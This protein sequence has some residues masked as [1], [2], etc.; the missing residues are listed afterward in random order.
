MTEHTFQLADGRTLAYA[1]YGAANAQPVLY[2]HGTPSSRLEPEVMTIYNQ[3]IETLLHQH[4]LQLISVD[5]PGIGLSSFHAERSLDSFA[6]DAA[7]LLRSLHIEK[8]TLLCWSGGGPYG[9]AMAHH[10]TSVIKGVYIIAGFSASFSEPGVIE[11]MS[12]NKVYFNT[13][14]SFPLALKSTF[15]VIKHLQV[16]TPIMQ[17]LYDLADIDYALL[18]DPGKLNLFL[19]CTLKEACRNGAEGP[20]QEAQVYFQ[21]FPFSLHAIQT[22][23]HFWWGTE[24]NMVT[25]VHAKK[26]EQEVPHVTP[27]YK[28]GQ[29]HVSIYVNYMNEVLQAIAAS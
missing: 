7:A 19:K 20:V 9:L 8:C 1:R 2:F 14:R 27:H 25:Y 10:Y 4:N 15:A 28:P 26:L 5:R 21:P 12:W 22:P 13:A 18:K 3:P 16:K 24:D 6:D 23:V 11:R 17:D 29:G